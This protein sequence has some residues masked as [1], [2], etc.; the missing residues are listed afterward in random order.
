MLSIAL[1]L[2]IGILRID[3]LIA[4]NVPIVDTVVSLNENNPF[5]FMFC[6]ESLLFTYVLGATTTKITGY[7]RTLLEPNF[8]RNHIFLCKNGI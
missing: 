8:N 4:W 2:F 3:H 6:K 1:G 5:H 7:L